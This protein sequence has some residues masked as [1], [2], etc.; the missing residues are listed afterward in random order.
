MTGI[1]TT[2]SH[3]GLNRDD[4]KVTNI[5]LALVAPLE[6]PGYTGGQARAATILTQALSARPGITLHNVVH[7][8]RE[9]ADGRLHAALLRLR[10]Y[11]DFVFILFRTRPDLVHF[12]APCSFYSIVE[13]TAMAMVARLL[14]AR[15]LL[16][17]R[18]D[19]HGLFNAS[20]PPRKRALAFMFRRY[21]GLLCQFQRLR[22]F[23]ADQT[24]VKAS[25]VHV[26]HNAIALGDQ[27]PTPDILQARFE[28]ARLIFL[29][30]LSQRKGIETLLDA[31]T[32]DTRAHFHLDIVGDPQP[33]SHGDHLRRLSEKLGVADRV[34]FHGPQF[35]EQKE[36]LLN[37]AACLVLPSRAEGF[38]NVVLEAAGLAVPSV[39]TRTGAAEDIHQALS[40]GA[41]LVD[42]DAPSQLW[43]SI[44]AIF[45][46][47]DD[48]LKRAEAARS[49]AAG[50][51]VGAMTDGFINAYQAVLDSGVRE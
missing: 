10:F 34:T 15:V 51:S 39:L 17:L 4:I 46:D 13:K 21:H 47:P 49:G 33:P 27:V 36:A 28:A 31:L 18:N 5:T 16:N 38:P 40:R 24:G 50:F 12:F 8:H 14:G 6:K 11:R 1:E 43:D 37:A 25:R 3:A 48:Y 2:T 42:V 32:R 23:Y 30:S 41:E 35:G 22:D 7:P 20:S 29:G 9:E 44:S 26:V 19:P 45:H